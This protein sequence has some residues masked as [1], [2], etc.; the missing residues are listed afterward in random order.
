VAITVTKDKVVYEGAYVSIKYP[1]GDIPANHGHCTNVIIQAYR[2]LRIDL[3]K[4]VKKN[5]LDLCLNLFNLF[6]N[7]LLENSNLFLIQTHY[8]RHVLLLSLNEDTV[9][10][11]LLF[12]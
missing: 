11:D 6:V 4:E 8:F 9:A 5:T 7:N 12:Q 1:N 3:R 10:A 2:K